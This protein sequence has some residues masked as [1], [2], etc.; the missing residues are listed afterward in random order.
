M[1]KIEFDG[2]KNVIGSQ[3]KL[4]RIRAKLNQ[5]EL[6]AKMQTYGVNIDQQMLSKIERDCRMVTDYELGLF[7]H[8][9]KITPQELFQDFSETYLKDE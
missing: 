5:D 2:H 6:A 1:K 3:L 8:I 7:C 4:A 9:L